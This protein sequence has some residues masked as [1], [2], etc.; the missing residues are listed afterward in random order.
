MII[1]QEFSKSPAS[2]SIGLSW[3]T[4]CTLNTSKF[5]YGEDL[6]L[7]LWVKGSTVAPVY[8]CVHGDKG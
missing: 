4:Y 5:K 7:V 3:L 2:W 1:L 8:E 6:V